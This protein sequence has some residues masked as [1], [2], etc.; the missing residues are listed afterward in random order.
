MSFN[1]ISRA[2]VDEDLI[3]RVTVAA[4]QIVQTDADKANTIFGQ[5]LLRGSMMGTNP[6]APLMYPV[7]ISTEA[8]YEAAL[9]GQR[10]APGYDIDIITDAA[11]F[12]AVNAAWP[13]ERPPTTTVPGA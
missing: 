12:A 2:A 3:K 4:N 7:A 10:G 11:L 1:S 13:M 6:V 5:S 8:A 9:L